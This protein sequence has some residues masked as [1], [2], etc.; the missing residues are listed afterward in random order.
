MERKCVN[1]FIFYI[2][3]ASSTSSSDAKLHTTRILAG[4]SASIIP[5]HLDFVLNHLPDRVQ[6]FSVL[7]RAASRSN[8]TSRRML[9]NGVSYRRY[10]NV[11][12]LYWQDVDQAWLRWHHDAQSMLTPWPSSLSFS[13]KQHAV[14]N[15][16]ATR[17]KVHGSHVAKVIWHT[18]I[19]NIIIVR[20]KSDRD[21]RF[22]VI[23]Q[24]SQ[25][26]RSTRKESGRLS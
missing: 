22:R 8:I 12:Q 9:L 24:A 7:V 13:L 26:L 10:W 15:P 6:D 18:L 25:Y 1:N 17:I 21:S 23:G 16:Y 11:M 19:R 2:L 4:F 14:L 5:G 20:S 3:R